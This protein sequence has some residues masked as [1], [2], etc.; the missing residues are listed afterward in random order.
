MKRSAL[1]VFTAM[2]V[3]S[4]CVR[5]TPFEED[6]N[7]AGRFFKEEKYAEAVRTFTEI[8]DKDYELESP[9]HEASIYV[10]RGNVYQIMNRYDDAL[11]DYNVAI[12]IAPDIGEPYANRGVLYDHMEQYEKA[13]ADYTK[14]LEL[15]EEL[16]EPPGIFRRILYNPSNIHTIKDRLEFLEG[17]MK[18]H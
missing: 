15:N 1:T 5:V 11:R 16:G 12:K 8:L 3:F 7:R 4:A 2:M 9:A 14:A 10:N 17:F 6:M 13:V 18:A